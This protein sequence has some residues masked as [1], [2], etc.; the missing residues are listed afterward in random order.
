MRY[1]LTEVTHIESLLRFIFDMFGAK[2]TL[3]YEQQKLQFL[4]IFSS[5]STQKFLEILKAVLWVADILKQ[6]SGPI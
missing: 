2:N 3:Y 5:S 1:I 6:V 4:S